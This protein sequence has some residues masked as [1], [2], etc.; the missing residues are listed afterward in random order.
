MLD[1][2][3]QKLTPHGL[4]PLFLSCVALLSLA[5][6]ALSSAAE[7]GVKSFAGKS[8]PSPHLIGWSNTFVP[9]AGQALLGNPGTAVVQFGLETTTFGYGYYLSKRSPLTLDG[10]PIDLPRYNRRQRL[11]QQDVSK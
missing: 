1:R 7:S 11:Q 9:G 5:L 6:P 3:S 10:V 8:V 2:T 4:S